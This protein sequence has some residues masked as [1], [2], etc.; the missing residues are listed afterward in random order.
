MVA[1]EMLS[2]LEVVALQ[3]LAEVTQHRKSL[4]KRLRKGV[5]DMKDGKGQGKAKV[6][7]PA[8]PYF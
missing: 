3:P 2:S 8:R 1:L 7:D 6:R 4:A 5:Q